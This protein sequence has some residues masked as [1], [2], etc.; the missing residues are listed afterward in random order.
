MGSPLEGIRVLDASWSL[1]GPYAA[2]MLG[3]LGARVIKVERPGVGD[4][5]REWDRVL[6]PW[7]SVDLWVNPNKESFALNLKHARGRE[8]LFELI[9]DAD[10]FI[11]SFTPGVVENLGIDYKR[12]RTQNPKIVYCHI[13]GYGQD[14]PYKDKKAMD[15]LIQGEA[16]LIALTGSEEQP[17]RLAASVADISAGLYAAFAVVSALC[18]AQRTGFGQELDVSLF[19]ATVSLLGYWVPRFWYK[20]ESPKRLGMRHPLI[21]PYGVYQ[22]RDGFINICVSTEAMWERFCEAIGHLELL[23]DSRFATNERRVAHRGELEPLLERVFLERERTLW[24]KLLEAADIPCAAVNSL[25]EVLAHPQLKH[26]GLVKSLQTPYGPLQLFA[27][28]VKL[29]KTPGQLKKPPPKLGEHTDS[30][31]KELGYSVAEIERLREEGV[32]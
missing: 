1:A 24:Q 14:G 6:G 9:R 21:V 11:E 17:A 5:S 26:R 18:Y 7:S 4:L 25:A 30:I 22:A 27:L 3:D 19:D 20:N 12:V 13:S 8:I 32:I 29:S 23:K 31:L 16:G 2:M 28:P 15:M 10:V